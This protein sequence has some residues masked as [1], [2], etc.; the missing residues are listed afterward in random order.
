MK[1]PG[2]IVGLTDE[3]MGLAQKRFGTFFP[4][5]IEVYVNMAGDTA[6]LVWSE[7]WQGGS[8]EAHLVKGVWV[9]SERDS[10]VT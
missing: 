9:L 7:R 6:L 10:W 5:S 3:E 2:Y 4:L 8:F 1:Q